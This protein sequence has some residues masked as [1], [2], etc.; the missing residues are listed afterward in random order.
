[1]GLVEGIIDFLSKVLNFIISVVRGMLLLS[2]GILLA[3]TIFLAIIANSARFT[4]LD[5]NFY[6][7]QLDSA[8]AYDSIK[9]VALDIMITGVASQGPDTP[10][11]AKAM[12]E[13][14]TELANAIPT[15]WFRNNTRKIVT[16][17]FAYLKGDTYQLDMKVSI[18]EIKPGLKAAVKNLLP[19]L[20]GLQQASSS[21]QATIPTGQPSEQTNEAQDYNRQPGGSGMPNIM[22]PGNCNSVV[23]CMEFCENH[24]N[25]CSKFDGTPY[26][27]RVN[28]T[29]LKS[30]CQDIDG[31]VP[32]CR[33]LVG[34]KLNPALGGEKG[35]CSRMLQFIDA[36][37]PG[38]PVP[39]SVLKKLPASDYILSSPNAPTSTSPTRGPQYNISG[40]GGCKNKT[41][42]TQYCVA[43]Q[44]ECKN[45][46]ITIYVSVNT[47]FFGSLCTTPQACLEY[48]RSDISNATGNVKDECSK[49]NGDYALAQE[50]LFSSFTAVSSSQPTEISSEM[51]DQVITQQ[52]DSIPDVVD[53]DKETQY[54]LSAGLGQGRQALSTATLACDLLIGVTIVFALIISL[55]AFSIKGAIR[56]VGW[57][58]FVAGLAAAL[59][60]VLAPK[61]ILDTVAQGLVG[62]QMA[63]VGGILMG[64]AEGLVKGYFNTVLVPAVIICLLGLGM[65]IL[66]FR[67]NDKEQEEAGKKDNKKEQEKEEVEKEK[68]ENNEKK[69]SRK[70]KNKNNN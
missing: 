46:N 28:W 20:M 61:M 21:S 14:R 16:N 58:L 18:A 27:L 53:L 23:G 60:A 32:Y 64:V 52:L 51:M 7:N 29:L 30:K 13:I 19:K 66:S 39:E 24:Y 11:R 54:Q 5:S 26:D 38:Q 37:A 31:C 8:N 69:A 4:L 10:E 68:P 43:H 6:L 44:D 40:P 12:V 42:C 62:P 25:E 65:L 45:A 59:L 41:E 34:T 63:Q 2:F 56:H 35:N 15:D 50:D 33:N 3:V 1:M 47:T 57:P 70:A 17:S 36:T 49:I 9:T 67:M 22:W 48:C 55:I